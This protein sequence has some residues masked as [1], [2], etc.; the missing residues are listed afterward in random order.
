MLDKFSKEPEIQGWFLG[1]HWSVPAWLAYL[2]WFAA[3][4]V[5]IGY[6]SVDPAALCL[7]IVSGRLAGGSSHG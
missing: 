3:V 6:Y 2:L 4:A 7:G 5:L 1:M